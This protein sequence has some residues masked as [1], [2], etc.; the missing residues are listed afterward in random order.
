VQQ[1]QFGEMKII[2]VVGGGVGTLQYDGGQGLD[3]RHLRVL[4][5]VLFGT[6]GV[7]VAGA[8]GVPDVQ[9]HQHLDACTTHFGVAGIAVFLFVVVVGTRFVLFFVFLCWF[10]R[11]SFQK[12][13]ECNEFFKKQVGRQQVRHSFRFDAPHPCD[14][15]QTTQAQHTVP[16]TLC[17]KVHLLVLRVLR[18]LLVLVLHDQQQHPIDVQHHCFHANGIVQNG[19]HGGRA[20]VGVVGTGR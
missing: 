10:H 15:T 14:Q 2:E 18:V 8:W 1:T 7:G 11:R 3:Q 12:G 5:V 17:L 20:G 9:H 4:I 6:W 16:T 19:P 13:H